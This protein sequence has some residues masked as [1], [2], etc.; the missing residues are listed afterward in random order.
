MS[1]VPPKS[2]TNV[3]VAPKPP[4][5]S[6]PSQGSPEGPS[7]R[8]P[9]SRGNKKATPKAVTLA[10][11]VQKTMVLSH[12][13]LRVDV[14]REH[15]QIWK[16]SETRLKLRLEDLARVPP[17]VIIKGLLAWPD[18]CMWLHLLP[19]VCRLCTSLGTNFLLLL[20]QWVA[21][22][23]L[24]VSMSFVRRGDWP[25]NVRKRWKLEF[26]C[27]VLKWDT[28]LRQR[29][30]LAGHQQIA[31]L[32]STGACI[33]ERAVLL[34]ENLEEPENADL[35]LTDVGRRCWRRLD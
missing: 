3:P 32:S 23:S 33:N 29:R 8:N 22:V 16:V 35:N 30:R 25:V 1:S 27:M 24:V 4:S 5:L 17:V 31:Q 21:S 11:A 26:E 14:N 12:K 18:N 34:M 10:G 15:G 19:H 9:H 28:P 20:P 2:N 7:Q 6:Q 13:V